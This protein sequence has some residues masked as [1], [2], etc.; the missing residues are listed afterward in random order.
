MTRYGISIEHPNGRKEW[1]EYR[2]KAENEEHFKK[3]KPFYE[4]RGCKVR[5]IQYQR[6]NG[7]SY[8]FKVIAE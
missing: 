8:N 4:N 1:S 2:S 3:I 7:S 5:L 6:A